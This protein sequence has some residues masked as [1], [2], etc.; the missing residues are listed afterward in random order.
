MELTGLK[1]LEDNGEKMK[2]LIMSLLI[3]SGALAGTTRYIEAD[4]IMSS[5]K[6]K[7]YTLPPVSSK[8]MGVI[9]LTSDPCLDSTSY[10]EGYL[11]YNDTSD[12]Y[13]F[14]DSIGT[15]VQLHSPT[16]ACF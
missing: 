11:F 7:T 1:S 15:D 4:E 14:C 5:D 10:P 9:K 13:C 2:F 8:I 6:T 16:T 12:Y 3:A